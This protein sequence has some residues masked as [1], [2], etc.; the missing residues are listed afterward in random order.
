MADT[1][2]YGEHELKKVPADADRFGVKFTGVYED[3]RSGGETRNIG[4]TQ[5]Q[6]DEL[7]ALLISFNL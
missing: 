6:F 1:F 3:G 2:N 4:L 7:S 5:E